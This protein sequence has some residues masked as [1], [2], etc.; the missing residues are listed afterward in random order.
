MLRLVTATDGEVPTRRRIRQEELD[1]DDDE[2]I[3]RVIAALVARRLL[4]I[5]DDSVELVHEALLERWPRLVAWLD[6]D[7]QGRR[8]HRHLTQ[9]AAEWRASRRD[10]SELYRGPRLAAALEWADNAG[11]QAGLNRLER[12]FLE[13]S[14]SAFAREAGRERRV[15][16][17]LRG[18]LA[19][20]LALL[21]A[22]AAAAFIA[23]RE[24]GTA[25]S[26]ATAAIAQRLGAQALDEPL[27]DRSLLLA[28]E[29]VRLDD[30]P[31]T[32][33]NLLAALLR[34]P[35]ALAVLHGGGT[36][37]LDDA[38][39]PDGRTLAVGGNDGSVTFFDTRTL[40]EERPRFASS[41]QI[42]NFGG[43]GRP[44]RALAFSPDGRTLAVGDSTGQGRNTRPR[45]RAH[46]PR[47]NDRDRA[48][49]RERGDCG[50]SLF[51]RR[52][53]DRD[54]GSRPRST[55]AARRGAGL[56]P[57]AGRQSA[58]CVAADSRRTS[59]RLHGR[60][61]VPPRHER[62][63]DLIPARRADVQ[64][65]PHAIASPAPQRSRRPA[66]RRP[67]ARTTAASS[68]S[69]CAPVSSGR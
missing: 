1:A 10:A 33:S 26:Q 12:E 36:R 25:R 35:A 2:N 32:R 37:V 23:A 7:A 43:I 50:R 31:A 66:T 59:D 51:S 9:A 41:G 5:D 63:D 17:R 38:L 55:I 64:A 62:R 22:V 27:L 13:E 20:A 65:H 14:R 4:V 28:R 19:A 58:S 49:E 46:P 39:S 6:E 45:R 57:Q 60:R 67:S 29:G 68:C 34:S 3:A 8:V 16:R 48:R 24:W 30:S 52:P 61:T 11:E 15:N 47:T 56:A 54:R 69:T 53:N 42:S 18:L 44:V 21:V 40:R